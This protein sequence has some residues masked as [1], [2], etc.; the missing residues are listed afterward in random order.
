MRDDPPKQQKDDFSDRVDRIRQTHQAMSR[1][2]V[3]EVQ[4]D[5]LIRPRVRRRWRFSI[6]RLLRAIILVVAVVYGI[7]LILFYTLG[8]EEFGKRL[9]QLERGNMIERAG[10]ALMRPDPLTDRII[11]FVPNPFLNP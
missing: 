5:G 7:K 11:T 4:E 10:A 2:F 9:S 8:E 3:Y 1:G 6:F